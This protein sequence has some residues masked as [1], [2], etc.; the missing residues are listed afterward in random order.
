MLRVFVVCYLVC[1]LAAVRHFLNGHH[2]IVAHISGLL[3]THTI[4]RTLNTQETKLLRHLVHLV[5][6]SVCQAA[7]QLSDFTISI[8]SMCTYE[9]S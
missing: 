3:T 2:L 4:I 5:T 7:C 9:K 8:F 6:D 1:L